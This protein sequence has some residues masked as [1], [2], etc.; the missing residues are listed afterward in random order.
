MFDGDKRNAVELC[1]TSKEIFAGQVRVAVLA[2]LGLTALAEKSVCFVKEQNRI[3]LLCSF[4]YAVEILFGFANG[5]ANDGGEVDAVKYEAG[6][7]RD[8]SG[9]S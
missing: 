6:L 7:A 3:V 1:Q 4:K 5:F 2:V 8:E 9:E